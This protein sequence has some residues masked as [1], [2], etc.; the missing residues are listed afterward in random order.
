M[1]ML[2]ELNIGSHE[3]TTASKTA[4]QIWNQKE[5]LVKH[6]FNIPYYIRK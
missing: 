5:T 1:D 4:V 6:A 3:Q 2:L